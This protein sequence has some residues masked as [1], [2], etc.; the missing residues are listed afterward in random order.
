MNRI[1]R[2][3]S[4][5]LAIILHPSALGRF[6]LLTTFL[7]LEFKR[8][9][10]VDLFGVRP[11]SETV[12]GQKMYFSDYGI[13][14]LVFNEVFVT[15]AYYFKA[16]ND[17]PVIVDGGANIGMATAYFKAL[18]PGCKVMAF[19]PNQRNFELL[20]QTAKANNWTGVELYPY[21]L[22]RTAGELWFF[23]YN[24]QPGSLSGGFWEPAEAGPAKSK[25]MVQTVP[26]SEYIKEDVDLLKLDVEGSEGAI[27]EDL[28]ATGKLSRVKQIIGEYHHHVNPDEDKLGGFL[29]LLER[30]GF[31]YH[32]RSVFPL[33]FPEK[34]TQDFMFSAYRK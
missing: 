11:E 10:L 29:S 8:T 18:Y 3:L 1:R 17:Q 13:F 32:F 34:Q 30:S 33:P 27:L 5:S 28:E 19:E 22:H 23:D 31:G 21:G 16:R 14:T 9:F 26:L 12:F 7:R 25:T 2:L 4:D 15:G 6:A 24:G 20:Q